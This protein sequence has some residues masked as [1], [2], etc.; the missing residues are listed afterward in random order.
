MIDH[1]KDWTTLRGTAPVEVL[2]ALGDALVERLRVAEHMVHELQKDNTRLVEER[3]AAV[4]EVK[5]RVREIERLR[6]AV[7]E[8]LQ[9]GSAS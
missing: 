8:K 1:L 6:D 4:A 7:R 9:Q 5:L 3:R 2:R